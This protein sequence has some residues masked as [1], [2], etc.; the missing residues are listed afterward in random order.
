MRRSTSNTSDSPI[1]LKTSSF[2]SVSSDVLDSD[3]SIM[4]GDSSVSVV[5]NKTGLSDST[6]NVKVVN[7]S[8]ISF[9]NYSENYCVSI[10]DIVG[11]TSLVST[12][13]SSEKVRKFYSIFINAMA[14]EI[15]KYNGRIVKTMGDGIMSYFPKTANI[16]DITA[17][18]D[19]MECCYTQV[20]VFPKIN[21]KLQMEK[22]PTIGYRI[23]A[24]YG[25]VEIARSL[26]SSFEDLYGPTINFC[27]K[28]NLEA[29]PNGIVI[30]ND[31]YRIIRSFPDFPKF[32]H[33]EE[34]Q[35]SKFQASKYSYPIYALSKKSTP[36]FMTVISSL[37]RYPSQ[38]KGNVDTPRK[39]LSQNPTVL[40]IDDEGDDLFTLEKFLTLE[41]YVVKSFSDSHEALQHFTKT[42]DVYDLIITDIRMPKINGVELYLKLKAVRGDIKIL[43]ASCLELAEEIL[44]VMPGVKRN[45]LI[46]K[47]IEQ[48]EFIEI[49]NKT[50]HVSY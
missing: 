17:F 18:E 8:E 14:D 21:S 31:L 29:S 12:I 27:S 13:R 22:L 36:T 33:F 5:K 7:A 46:K 49:V 10:V 28:I 9:S 45:Q 43:F 32:W 42:S 16:T 3:P 44:S 23:S 35:G 30:G 39:K 6:D 24:D 19:V 26:T 47:P 20:A 11:S 37:S 4:R 50:I 34:L 2:V 25:R 40:L 41:G 15:K 1:N 38:V 48:R